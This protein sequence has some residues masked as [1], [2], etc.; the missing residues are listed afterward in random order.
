MS[1][2]GECDDCGQT[3]RL[4]YKPDLRPEEQSRPTV[5]PRCHNR[6]ERLL[7]DYRREDEQL[8]PRYFD[9]RVAREYVEALEELPESEGEQ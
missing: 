8:P 4:R 3:A 9:D 6:R 2:M 1:L 5:C 7:E